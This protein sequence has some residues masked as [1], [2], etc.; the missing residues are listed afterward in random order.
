MRWLSALLAAL[1]LAGG[2]LTERLETW[3]QEIAQLGNQRI[4]LA[5][6]TPGNGRFSVPD[7]T[8]ELEMVR[9][10]LAQPGVEEQLSLAYSLLVSNQTAAGTTHVVLLN[11]ARKEEWEPGEEALLAHEFGHAWIKAKGFP[12]PRF[13][14]GPTACLSIHT[15]DVVQHVLIRE[16]MDR[17]GIDHRSHWIKALERSLDFHEKQPAGKA[18]PCETVREAALWMDVRLGLSEAQWGDKAR[19]ENALRRRFPAAG[20]QVDEMTAWLK[21]KDLADK[22]VHREALGFVFER[23]RRAATGTGMARALWPIGH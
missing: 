14:P 5:Q 7:D 20:R 23:L 3:R 6:A 16:E 8:G 19:Y 11:M 9:L 22:A 13:I 21:D 4:V 10:I 15:A 12:V 2:E 18:E 1:P 17:R